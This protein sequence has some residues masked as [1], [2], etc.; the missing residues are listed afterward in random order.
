MGVS[1]CTESFGSVGG[2][3]SPPFGLD[4]VPFRDRGAHLEKF[5][6]RIQSPGVPE[7]RPSSGPWAA[8]PPRL[9]LAL[10]DGD[11]E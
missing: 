7:Q 5:R 3:V 10:T 4:Q 2:L 6:E 1:S 8:T 9:G 11:M